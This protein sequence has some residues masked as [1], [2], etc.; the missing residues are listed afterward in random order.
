MISLTDVL[1]YMLFLRFHDISKDGQKLI[2]MITISAHTI[3]LITVHECIFF[4]SLTG[5]L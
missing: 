4:Q 3:A 1:W 5:I 2:S